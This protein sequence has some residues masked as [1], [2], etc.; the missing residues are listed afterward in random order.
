VKMGIGMGV[1]V[2]AR[3]GRVDKLKGWRRG[4]GDISGRPEKAWPA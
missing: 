1:R 4:K 3:V 2:G